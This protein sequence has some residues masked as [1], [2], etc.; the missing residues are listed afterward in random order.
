MGRQ[1]RGM[2]SSVSH[3]LHGKQCIRQSGTLGAKSLDPI[4]QG[5]ELSLAGSARPTDSALNALSRQEPLDCRADMI[6]AGLR[7]IPEGSK[8]GHEPLYDFLRCLTRNLNNCGRIREIGWSIV[9]HVIAVFPMNGVIMTFIP[10]LI[11]S[12]Y[13]NVSCTVRALHH[14]N[15]PAIDPFRLKRVV[16]LRLV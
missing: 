12:G 7:I 1:G 6:G 5:E 8:R 4:V 2:A 3:P 15:E 13:R 11:L 9:F 14:A 10:Y 16:G